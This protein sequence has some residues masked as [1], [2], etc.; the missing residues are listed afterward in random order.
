MLTHALQLDSNEHTKGAD[1]KSLKEPIQPTRHRP[2][3]SEIGSNG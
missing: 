2:L 1:M 3:K